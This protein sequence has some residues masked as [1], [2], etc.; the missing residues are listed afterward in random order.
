MAAQIRHPN[1]TV[2]SSFFSVREA[3]LSEY[4]EVTPRPHSTFFEGAFV[5]ENK[6]IREWLKLRLERNNRLDLW[7][8]GRHGYVNIQSLV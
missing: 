4:P 3:F 8:P 2:N 6:R 5:N 7:N 1:V